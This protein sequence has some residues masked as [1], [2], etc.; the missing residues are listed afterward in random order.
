MPPPASGPDE[1]PALSARE[2]EILAGI[3]HD[4]DSSSPALA[5]AMA[6]PLT[7]TVPLPRATV[8]ACLLVTALFLVLAVTGLVPPAVWALL[9]ALAAMVVVPW[10]MLRAFERLDPERDTGHNTD[11]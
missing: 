9:A 11:R 6:R 3:E 5:R 1:P 4:L 2:R 8:R 7:S 10:A